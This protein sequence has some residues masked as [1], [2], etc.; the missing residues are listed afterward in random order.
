[1]PKLTWSSASAG[2]GAGES[3]GQPSATTRPSR[4]TSRRMGESLGWWACADRAR[5]MPAAAGEE[6]GA[7]GEP[8][9]KAGLWVSMA[10]RMAD[11]SGLPAMVL[12]KGDAD[13]GG[14]LAVLRGRAGM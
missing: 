3:T 2:A 1:M 7:M 10:L 4:V 9:V 13:A 14:V 12:Q 5:I 8:R 6:R 11:R